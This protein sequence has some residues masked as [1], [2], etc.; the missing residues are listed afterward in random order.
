MRDPATSVREEQRAS[1]S[2]P[3][4]SW[5]RQNSMASS[6]PSSP[7]AVLITHSLLLGVVSQFDKPST[8]WFF[9][10]LLNP[11]LTIDLINFDN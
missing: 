5:L 2:E 7:S 11:K 10:L 3:N 4:M 9:L 8:P 1:A 6:P